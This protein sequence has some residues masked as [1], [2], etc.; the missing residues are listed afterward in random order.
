MKQI[1]VD[2]KAGKFAA[3]FWS[4]DSGKYFIGFQD[5]KA[6]LQPLVVYGVAYLVDIP[7]YLHKGRVCMKSRYREEFVDALDA[8]NVWRCIEGYRPGD[9]M[10]KTS[11]AA[12]KFIAAKVLPAL[13]EDF[14]TRRAE[15]I[16]AGVAAA[17]EEAARAD[18]KAEELEAEAKAK[19]KE[20]KEARRH[21]ENLRTAKPAAQG[22]PSFIA[23]PVAPARGEAN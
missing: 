8:E 18:E 1:Y 3:V 12:D 9:V 14:K 23:E 21:A 19:R 7:L 17:L 22:V 15:R 2:T 10:A 6:G 16:E 13:V 5:I 20:A 11:S 4:A